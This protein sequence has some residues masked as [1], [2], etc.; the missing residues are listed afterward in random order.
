MRSIIEIHQNGNWIPAAEFV[1]A[2][3]RYCGTFGY[4]PDYVF[5]D[6]PT[7]ISFAQPVSMEYYGIDIDKGYQPLP[8]F[9]LDLVPQGRGR[10]YLARELGIADGD[11]ADLLLAQHG[12]FNPI[13]N[14]RLNTAVEFYESHKKEHPE[15]NPPGYAIEDIAARQSAFLEHIWLH[16][17]LT[18]GTTGVQG[19]APK[20]LLTQNHDGLWFADAALP[21]A[22]QARH[23]L[24]KLPRGSHE[25]DYAVLRNE[26]AY[27]RVAQ[28]CG[29]R[30]AGEPMLLRD[31]LFAPRF[32]RA[33]D[34]AG[35]H[36]LSQETLASLAGIR[37]FG[38]PVPLFELVRA[39]Q[40][41]VDDPVGEIVEFIRRDILNMAMR[42]TDNHA[43]NTSVQRLPDGRVQLTPVYDFAPMYLDR[44]FVVRGCKWRH[45]RH[46]GR[47]LVEWNDIVD[48][49]TLSEDDKESVRAGLRYFAKTVAT[50]PA[51]MQDCGVDDFVIDDCKPTIAEQAERLNRV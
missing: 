19:A 27:L 34:Q 8:A 9:L 31:M 5:G 38:V 28:H 15:G 47:E 51:I 18:A 6:A 4:L 10:T 33:V 17:M 22:D 50:L 45:E 12:A 23:W 48:L 1:P 11:D 40:P 32:D 24:V 43:R 35:L 36:R 26:A 3:A 2:G 29:L 25:T 42:N 41:H 49:L 16:A 30:V 44:E 20:F 21:D 46:H 14:L 39:F 7:P 37:A 13:G